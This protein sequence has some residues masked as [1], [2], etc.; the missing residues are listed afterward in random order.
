MAGYYSLTF[1]ISISSI[2]LFSL[3]PSHFISSLSY[4]SPSVPFLPVSERWC[5]LS[6]IGW[7]VIKQE[8]ISLTPTLSVWGINIR[9]SWY[10]LEKKKAK[11]TTTKYMLFVTTSSVDFA[12]EFILRRAQ[13][14]CLSE[15]I[16]MR[17]KKKLSVYLYPGF[18]INTDWHISVF[19]TIITLNLLTS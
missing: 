12:L 5:I 6:H 3:H 14:C 16:F 2:I 4:T 17:N 7:R 18:P 15:T 10:D 9:K 19:S 13:M 11:T 1:F 8:L